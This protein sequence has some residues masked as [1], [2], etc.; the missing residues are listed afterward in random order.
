MDSPGKKSFVS[1]G[2][3]REILS[4]GHKENTVSGE[5]LSF[6]VFGSLFRRFSCSCFLKW[7]TEIVSICSGSSVSQDSFSDAIFNNIFVVVHCL[8]LLH[9]EVGV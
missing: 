3:N 5:F 1:K 9:I 8:T 6:I 7:S 4:V 2:I